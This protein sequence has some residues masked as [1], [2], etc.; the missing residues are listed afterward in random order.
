MDTVIPLKLA[1]RLNTFPSR[2]NLDQNTFLFDTDR[3][4]EGDEFLCLKTGR[5]EDESYSMKRS[6]Y[7]GLCCF[8]IE[9][10]TGIHL[11]R[12]TPRDDSKNF[13]AKLN[14]LIE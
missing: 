12:N 13:L 9:R 11:C 7:L 2:C 8:L 4:V 1:S 3:V 6:A 5:S 10:K 14:E